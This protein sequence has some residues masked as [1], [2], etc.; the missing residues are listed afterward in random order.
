METVDTYEKLFQNKEVHKL[1]HYLMYLL[2]FNGDTFAYWEQYVCPMEQSTYFPL[3]SFQEFID[4]KINIKSIGT[5]D[6]HQFILSMEI[7]TFKNNMVEKYKK[8]SLEN[9]IKNHMV[10]LLEF[11][12]MENRYYFTREEEDNIGIYLD[13]TPFYEYVAKLGGTDAVLSSVEQTI[14]QKPITETNKKY[15][16]NEALVSILENKVI[17]L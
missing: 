8:Y 9:M 3:K 11:R 17:C 16:E 13:M 2:I 6:Y 4:E 1:L 12:Q 15:I 14:E 5:H 7:P 10:F